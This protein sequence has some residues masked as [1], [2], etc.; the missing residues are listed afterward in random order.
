MKRVV[1]RILVWSLLPLARFVAR[2]GTPLRRL[3]AHAM[4]SA[5]VG[6]GLDASVVVQG[7][8]EVQ[9]TARVDVGWNLLLYRDLYLETREQ[10]HISLGDDVVIS[11]GVHI[12]S[13]TSVRIGN[14]AM[15][16][17]Y[18]SIRD[19]NHNIQNVS[20]YR[21]SG[22]RALPITIGRNVWIG[23]G[24]TVLPGVTIGEN[25]VI[26]ANSVVTKDVPPGV[27]AVG[28]PARPLRKVA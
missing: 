21:T 3:W 16:G 11:R 15:I 22:H 5:A 4:L 12:V 26:G 18:A 19:A 17:E 1:K 20:A 8:V 25:A 28:A 14:G 9:G 7:V 23:C 6:R 24:V 27:V 2:W 10:G 13:F